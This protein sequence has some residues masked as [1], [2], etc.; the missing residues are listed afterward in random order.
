MGRTSLLDALIILKVPAPA[1]DLI[2]RFRGEAGRML[3]GMERHRQPE[4]PPAE[5]PGHRQK[6]KAAALIGAAVLIFTGAAL[7]AVHG[8]ARHPET[9]TAHENITTTVFWVGEPADDSNAGIH[10]RSSAWVEDWEGEFGGVDDP[11]NRCG[12]LPCGFVPRENPFYV[13]LPYND[14][15]ASCRPKAS[16]QDVPWFDGAPGEG[17]SIVKNHWVKITYGDKTAYA[18]WEDAGP[19][20]EDDAAYVF[21]DA[22]AHYKGAGLDVSP[23]INDY[24]GLDGEDRTSWEFVD[25]SAVPDGPWTQTVTTSKPDCAR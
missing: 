22:A 2:N 15:D 9:E 13:A 18:Q 25:A 12:M 1:H 23:A 8:R 17:E 21:G 11:D 14:L 16:Q 5:A 4:L 24:L 19:M 3:A 7:L 10:N 20:G 6:I